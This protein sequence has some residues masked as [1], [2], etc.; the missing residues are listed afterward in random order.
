MALAALQGVV[1]IRLVSLSGCSPTSDVLF[2]VRRLYRI[3]SAPLFAK[4]HSLLSLRRLQSSPF[5]TLLAFR[6]GNL[7]WG[8]HSLFATSAEASSPWSPTPT[9]SSVLDVSHVF[10][11]LIRLDLVGLFH[12]TAA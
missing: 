3:P 1:C 4:F 10:D 9:A 8:Q 11:G 2:A 5:V 6:L 12:P 7:P